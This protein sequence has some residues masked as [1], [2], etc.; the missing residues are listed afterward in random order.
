MNRREALQLLAATGGCSF[1]TMEPSAA[2]QSPRANMFSHGSSDLLL[3]QSGV[4]GRTHFV[5]GL[6]TCPDPA[7]AMLSLQKLRAQTKF[8]CRLSYHSRNKFKTSY[9]KAALDYWL[10]SSRIMIR[11]TAIGLTRGPESESQTDTD[12]RYVEQIAMVVGARRARGPSVRLV[13]QPRHAGPRNAVL[14]RLVLKA[15][16][17]VG[18]VVSID[19]RR[20]DLLQLLGLVTGT[21][22]SAFQQSE[23]R[24]TN[25]IKRELAAYLESKLGG[26]AL[27]GPVA[28]PRLNVRVL[29]KG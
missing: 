19:D 20:S 23:R 13:T 6:L 25:A 21:I 4:F 2:A 12:Y 1:Y 8:Q 27:W 26:K 11:A 5:V 14:E 22:H 15:S 10:N 16:Q 18:E 29:T 17:N 28:H 3:D 9:A 7:S 24:P